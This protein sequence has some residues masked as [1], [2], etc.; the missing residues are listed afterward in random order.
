MKEIQQIPQIHV[1]REEKN[2][3]IIKKC[4]IVSKNLEIQISA[5]ENKG[6]LFGMMYLLGAKFTLQGLTTSKMRKKQS[7]NLSQFHKAK[8]L[9]D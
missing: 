8:Y 7:K 1:T 4:L 6:E 2:E 3:S 5:R 9:L